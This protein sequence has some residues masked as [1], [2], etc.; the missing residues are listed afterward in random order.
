LKMSDQ[1]AKGCGFKLNTGL[2][3]HK[4]SIAKLCE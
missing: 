2:F 3:V 4:P 1:A